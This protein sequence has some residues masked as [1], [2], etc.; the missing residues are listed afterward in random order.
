M[1]YS[2]DD[3][4]R[5]AQK[6]ADE[7]DLEGLID[8]IDFSKVDM[9]KLK[10][11]DFAKGADKARKQLD[12]MPKVRLTTQAPAQDHSEGGFIGGLLLGVIAG[13]IIALLFAPKSGEDT[14]GM[15]AQ[16]VEDLK[17]QLG[18]EH[19]IDLNQVVDVAEEEANDVLP[20]EPAIE[21][22]FG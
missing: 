9:K 13:A 21:R 2:M 22:N 3:F 18:G 15:V 17:D 10:K 7:L 11:I 16:T 1:S 5:Y 8:S 19:H 12:Q 6:Y 4:R 14:R 20:D